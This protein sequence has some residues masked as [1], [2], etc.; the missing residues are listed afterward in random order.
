[1]DSSWYSAV[2]LL[3]VA[4]VVPAGALIGA[5]VLRVKARKELPTKLDTYECGEEPDGAAWLR[6]H[7]RYYV[8]ALLFVIFD[9]E[10]VFMLPWALTLESLGVVAWVEM[11]VFVAI[12]M[13]GWGYAVRKGAIRW[14]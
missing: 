4:L 3:A 9:V 1:V 5:R 7:P 11:L 6:F 8:V 12:L 14:Q 10:T 13:L 2:A